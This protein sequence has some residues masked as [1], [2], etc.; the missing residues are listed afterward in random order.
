VGNDGHFVSERPY[1]SNESTRT[2]A[3]SEFQRCSNMSGQMCIAG[4]RIFVQEGIYDKFIERFCD[5]ARSIRQGDNFDPESE[6]G[7]VVSEAQM[8]VSMI[9]EHLDVMRLC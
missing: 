1:I 9:A 8:N 5:A 4:S 7:P 3:E 2:D 6:Q